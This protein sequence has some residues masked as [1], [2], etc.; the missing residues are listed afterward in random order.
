MYDMNRMTQENAIREPYN[1]SRSAGST[2]GS[3]AARASMVSGSS[4]QSIQAMPTTRTDLSNDHQK[5]SRWRLLAINPGAVDGYATA[6]M[7][8]R[9]HCPVATDSSF[10]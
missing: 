6:L 2:I 8:D 9:Q 4:Q 3:G 5:I 7:I 10:H 1:R